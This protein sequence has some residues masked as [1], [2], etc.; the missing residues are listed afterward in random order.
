MDDWAIYQ[1]TV[2]RAPELFEMSNFNSRTTG[3]PSSIEV[4]ARTDPFSHGHNRYRIK[5]TKNKEWAA[6]FTVSRN[7]ILVKNIN[8]ALLSSEIS[9]IIDWVG[10]F[11]PLIIS[12][13]DGRLDSAE[14]SLELNKIRG[15][16]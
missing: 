15:S 13:I 14:F 5:V 7:P 6:I 9:E 1:R 2:M 4:W 3:L 10:E 16:K 8:G 11:Y 12:L